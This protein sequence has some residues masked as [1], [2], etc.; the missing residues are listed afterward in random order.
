MTR[1]EA[2]LHA[3][4]L[5]AQCER[6]NMT[7]IET[8]RDQA[9]NFRRLGE[10]RLAAASEAVAAAMDAYDRESTAAIRRLA[11]GQT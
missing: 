10:D 6:A 9:A 5:L 8:F 11:K 7:A 1:D 2:I 4:G 3:W